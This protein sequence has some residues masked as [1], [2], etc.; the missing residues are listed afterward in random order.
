MTDV[1]VSFVGE[2][3]S[4]IVG[5]II[6]GFCILLLIYIFIL[7]PLPLIKKEK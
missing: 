7:D 4:F 1:L 2:Y 6:I 3:W 5:I